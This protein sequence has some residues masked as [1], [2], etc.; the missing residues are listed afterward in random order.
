MSEC[1]STNGKSW[2]VTLPLL[3]RMSS[4][5]LPSSCVSWYLLEGVFK[6]VFAVTLG[7]VEA[8]GDAHN[9]ATLAH[10]ILQIVLRAWLVV[11]S[12]A[13]RTEEVMI[14]VR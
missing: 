12:K 2:P 3:T 11:R 14:L 13:T 9:V 5:S 1:T 7:G 6:N 10:K 4:P 8:V